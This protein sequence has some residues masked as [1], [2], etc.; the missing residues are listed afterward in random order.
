MGN[1]LAYP[2]SVVLALIYLYI[3]ITVYVLSCRHRFMKRLYGRTSCIVSISLAVVASI[4]LG[5]TASESIIKSWWFIA[6][7]FWLMTVVGLN[8]VEDI[9]FWKH[10]PKA[11]VLS[12]IGVFLIFAVSVFG[13]AD[14]EDVTVSAFVDQPVAIGQDMSGKKVD[15]PFMLTLNEF[16][17]E[18]YEPRIVSSSEDW[19]V[20]TTAYYDMALPENDGTFREMKHVG[21]AQAALVRAENSRTSESAEGWVSCGSFLVEAKTLTLDDGT[22]ISMRQPMPKSYLS[23]VHALDAKGRSHDMEIRVNH[24]GRI[25]SWRL[26]Q[27]DYDESRGRWST[28]SVLECVRDPWYPVAAAALLLLLAAGVIALLSSAGKKEGRK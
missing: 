4:V 2:W 24:P 28:E 9:H 12:H 21:A 27:Y 20:S 17:M 19:T 15:L 22:V 25:G 23:R 11:A 3:I 13:S 8:M 7:M 26:Y 10:R 5:L 18:T 16:R 6:V 1:S 14:K